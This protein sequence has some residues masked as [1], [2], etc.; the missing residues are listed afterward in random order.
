M[1]R[2]PGRQLGY[3]RFRVTAEWMASSGRVE[4]W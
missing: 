3:Q 1:S 2:R 4:F